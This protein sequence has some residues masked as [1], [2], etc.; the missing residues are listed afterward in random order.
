MKKYFAL[1][2]VVLA[3]FLRFH[4]LGAQSFWNDEGNS[5]RLAERS[6]SLILAG[7]A[8]DIHP[9]GYYL[10]L[11]AWRAALGHSEFALRGL[12]ALAGIV[13]VALVY[14]LGKQYF[15]EPAAL[16]S[17]FFAAVHP[18]LIYYSQ[19]A[20]MYELVAA[21][22]AAAFLAMTQWLIAARNSTRSVQTSSPQFIIPYSS[23]VAIVLNTA[24]GLYTHYSF[25]FVLIALNL[26]ALGGML[27]H[28]ARPTP[29]TPRPT[30]FASRIALWLLLQLIALA[31]FAPWLPT[32]V[33][34]LATWPSAREYH[35]LADS[36]LGVGHWLTL[37]PTADA[38][39]AWA[40]LL[41]A[42]ILIGL[43]LRRRG[44]TITPL[45]WL[46][47]PTGL[48]LSFGLFSP[49][50][51]KFLII[52]VPALCLLMGNGAASLLNSQFA[53]QNSKFNIHRSSFII[54]TLLFLLPTALS[55]NNLY[56]NPDFARA[57][58]RGMA[59]ALDSIAKPGD[60]IL[61]NAPN[62]WE[63]FTYYHRD[64]SNVFPVA[65]TRPLDVPAQTAE[66]EQIA[67]TH[68][69]LFVLYWGDA[70]S[71]PDRVIETWLNAHTFKAYDQWHGDV[72]LAAYAVPRAAAQSQHTVNVTFGD[73]ITLV[74]YALNQS[75]FAPGDIL[76]L[77]LFW[78]AEQPIATR[79]KV[80]VHL[81][82]DPAQRPPAQHDGE[83]GG[84]L[85]LTTA[86]Q[87]GLMVPDN[88][89][90]YLPLDLPSGDYALVVGLYRL[91]DGARLTTDNGA[92]NLTLTAVTIR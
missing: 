59:A 9:P 71:D 12:S 72:R 21:L 61:L 57:D 84:G 70:Q 41:G 5:A 33:H 7:A 66:L 11:A 35:S 91:D 15:D 39:S 28:R 73:Q 23:C 1:L 4:R 45:L 62:Q 47:V 14:R 74:G 22:A 86:W 90:V 92:D 30:P 24:L 8:G 19:E 31:L 54:L 48:T 27:A 52:A 77:T 80:F 85:A 51:A 17:A 83:P 2:I 26:T 46:L 44:Q 79:Y 58:Y 64:T 50:F 29:T 38:S 49:A 78:R 68:D 55:L 60:A 88:H 40:A 89:G 36:L 56:F 16:A 10:L 18:A 34:Q 63:V 37:G 81:V 6:V 82:G 13:L 87:P 75:A 65:R 25:A 20:R 76:Q 53:T 42:A 32:A 3:A 43:G 67:A 69:R